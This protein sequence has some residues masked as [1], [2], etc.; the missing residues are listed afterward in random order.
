MRECGRRVSFLAAKKS[1]DRKWIGAMARS[2]N[3]ST[4]LKKISGNS[5]T[6]SFVERLSALVVVVG[7]SV[8]SH[9]VCACVVVVFMANGGGEEAGKHHP[10][11]RV[12]SSETA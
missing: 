11:S 4:F 5:P 3:A 1:M 7:V 10:L 2:M 12:W 6:T 8:W 9:G